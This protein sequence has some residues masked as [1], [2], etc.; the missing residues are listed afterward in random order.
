MVL[1]TFRTVGGR[2]ST[3]S[4]KVEQE[5]FS[6]SL[7]CPYVKVQVRAPLEPPEFMKATVSP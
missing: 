4:P 2:L 5:G 1:K 6:A 3:T 7:F